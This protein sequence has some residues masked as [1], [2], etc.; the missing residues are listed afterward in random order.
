MN[1]KY[2]LQFNYI[3]EILGID[4]R[5]SYRQK[6]R[7]IFVA[8]QK[9]GVIVCDDDLSTISVNRLVEVGY[10]MPEGKF[11]QIDYVDID[12]I[13]AYQGNE[14][15]YNIFNLFWA[16]K[17]HL[18]TPDTVWTIEY[19]TLKDM[20]EIKHNDTI[21]GIVAILGDLKLIIKDNVGYRLFWDGQIKNSSYT[22]AN[23]GN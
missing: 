10:N 2:D 16:I 6:V 15:K 18:Y 12:K 11:T 19:Q 8:M 13:I 9:D 5:S 3:Y 7:D 20:T 4:R 17:S 14:S 23:S 22:F 1:N 21:R